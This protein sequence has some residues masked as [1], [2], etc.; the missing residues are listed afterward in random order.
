MNKSLLSSPHIIQLDNTNP[1]FQRMLCYLM[2]WKAIIL[3]NPF[4]SFWFLLGFADSTISVFPDASGTHGISGWMVLKDTCFYWA[5]TYAELRRRFNV[6]SSLIL[7]SGSSIIQY[8]ELL[9]VAINIAAFRDKL[10]S[11]QMIR[12]QLFSDNSGIIYNIKKSRFKRDYQSNS[13]LLYILFTSFTNNILLSPHHVPILHNNLADLLSRLKFKE[14]TKL[15]YEQL[16]IRKFKR[17]EP[18]YNN[19]INFDV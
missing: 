14:F 15:A 7:G 6:P 3:S 2:C 10:D 9:A 16:S 1:L 18:P 13:L 5:I 12:I 11:K 19:I 8:K 17:I 4:F